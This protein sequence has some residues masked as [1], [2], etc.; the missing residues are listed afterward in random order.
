MAKLPSML[1]IPCLLFLFMAIVNHSSSARTIGNP[2]PTHHTHYHKITFLMRDV[3]NVSHPSSRPATTKVTGQLPFQK[4]LG[5][6]PPNGAIPLLGSDP[7]I[8]S[9]GLSTQTLDLS[10]IGLS[11][12]ARATLQELE[13]GTVTVIEEEIFKGSSNSMSPILGKAQGIY[14][15][16]SEDGSSHMIAMTVYFAGTDFK[17]GL[18][19][20]GVHQTDVAESQIAIIGGI[21]KYNGAN[22]YATIKAVGA[23]S[24]A[25]RDAKGSNKLLLFNVYLS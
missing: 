24:H 14:V 12:P 10:S 23:G 11:F 3:L 22:G 16:S 20:F 4:P 15:A 19:F 25:D 9:T 21:G 7:M 17:D 13:F 2:T 6:F 1:V 8:P 18:R 5:L